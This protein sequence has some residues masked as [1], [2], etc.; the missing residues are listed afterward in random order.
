MS[1][2]DDASAAQLASAFRYLVAKLEFACSQTDPAEAESFSLNWVINFLIDAGVDARLL[3]PLV[4]LSQRLSEGLAGPA[5]LGIQETS[6]L[7]EACAFVT[8]LHKRHRYRVGDAI[9]EVSDTMHLEARKLQSYRDNIHR[10]HHRFGSAC[11][12][13]GIEA[14]QNLSLAELKAKIEIC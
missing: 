10:G 3:F 8:V 5:F 11:Y 9:K 4:G 14:H 2:E 7:A 13:S 1:T 6:R 12:R